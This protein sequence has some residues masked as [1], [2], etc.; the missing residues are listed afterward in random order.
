MPLVDENRALALHGLRR[1]A[2]T[3]K[4]GLQALMRVAGVDPAALDESAIGFR[5][6]P[7][8]N[9][10]GRLGRPEAALALLLT[11]DKDEAKALAEELE[12]LNRERQVVEE[13]ILRE[14]VDADRVVAR[15]PPTASRLRRRGG[16]LAR[17]RDR[18]RRLAS[19]RAITTAPSW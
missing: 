14:A 8:I 12:T 1:L 19:R 7:R 11:E 9:A 15:S 13:R 18:D 6:A 3:Q 2:Q 16:G 4:A 5:L 17:G 10:S